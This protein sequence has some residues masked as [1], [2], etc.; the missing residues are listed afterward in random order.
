MS[1]V[2]ER[3]FGEHQILLR[4][5]NGDSVPATIKLGCR[6]WSEDGGR[7]TECRIN[8]QW[9]GGEIEEMDW[10]FF[11]S[12]K[13]VREKL[14]LYNL[15][16]ICYGASRRIVLSGMAVDM[17]LGLKVYKVGQ[18]G[19]VCPPVVCIFDSGDDV[20]PVS[21]ESQEQ[22]QDEWRRIF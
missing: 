1:K 8:L 16:P 18:D 22:F 20:E 6:G 14:A 9:S 4:D 13:H 11:E 10:H 2:P 7:R 12:F 21:V 3:D 15:L 17:S 19:Q 5:T